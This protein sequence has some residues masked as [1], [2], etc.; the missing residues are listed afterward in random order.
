M[1]RHIGFKQE[2]VALNFLKKKGLK[3]I[4][5]N[6]SNKGGE[7]DIIMKDIKKNEIIFIEVKYRKSNLYGTAAE[8]VT[9]QKQQKIINTSIYFLKKHNLYDKIPIRFD[10]IAINNDPISPIEWIQNAFC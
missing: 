6:F 5:Q 4:S 9:Y 10:I 8:M 7:I 1:T 2:Q 3:L